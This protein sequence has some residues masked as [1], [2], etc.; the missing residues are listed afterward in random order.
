MR[1]RVAAIDCGTNS[2]RLLI[3]DLSLSPAGPYLLDVHRE[4]RIVRLGQGVDA[5]GRLAP[6]ALDR[7]WHALADYAAIILAS[8]VDVT[9]MTATSAT[10]DA[11]NADEFRAMV[12][13][14]LG[15]EPEVI[16]G[17]EEAALSFRG[18]VGD[19]PAS[20]GPFLVVDIGGGSTEFVVGR[21]DAADAGTNGLDAEHAGAAGSAGS[22][23]GAVWIAGAVSQNIGSVR[24]TERLL[25][26]NPPTDTEIAAARAW[27]RDV[28]GAGLADLP[29]GV[30]ASVR[31]VVAVAGTATTVAAGVL[32]LP[33]YD[34]PKIHL[35]RLPIDAI[36]TQSDALLRM[37]AAERVSLGYMHP[38]RAD[39]IGGGSLIL[40]TVAEALRERLG[41]AQLTISEHDILDGIALSLA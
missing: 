28:V 24:I 15:Q 7:T 30:L 9:R 27:A 8:G 11:A 21:A 38:G 37:S 22:D 41:I 29:T 4:M 31:T 20:D 10:R 13:G 33:V 17:T 39:V 18:A 40:A 16:A 36:R 6:E 32:E 25:R 26:G 1:K 12:V 23:S 5:T 2:I 14:T 3:A 34:P 19:L 35:S